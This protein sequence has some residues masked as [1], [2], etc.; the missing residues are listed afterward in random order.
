[1]NTKPVT[2]QVNNSGAW[3]SVIR[4]DANDD[5]KSTQVLD[6]ADTLARIDG[7]SKFRVVMDNGL[8][9]VL[10]HWSAKDDWK[11]WRKP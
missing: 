11:P 5:M 10:M 3:K 9:A 2:L 1:M 8:Q 7:R 4:F 6:A